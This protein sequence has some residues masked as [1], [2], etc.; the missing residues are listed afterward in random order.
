VYKLKAKYKKL[1]KILGLTI[2]CFALAAAVFCITYYS[3]VDKSHNAYEGPIKKCISDVSK[4]NDSTSSL[5]KNNNLNEELAKKELVNKIDTLTKIKKSITNMIPTEKYNMS[6]NSLLSGLENNIMV[7]RQINEIVKNPQAKDI[8]KALEDLKKYETDCK[9]FY[10]QVSIDGCK[11]SLGD[12]CSKF[13]KNTYA[14]GS[15]QVSIRK[16]NEVLASQNLEFINSLDSIATSFSSL[17]TDLYTDVI[18]GRSSSFDSVISTI[19]KNKEAISLIRQ[20]FDKLSIPA[21][22]VDVYKSLNTLIDNYDAYIQSINYA[23]NVEKQDKED[24]K[25][26]TQADLDQLYNSANTKFTEINDE[27]ESF[28]KLFADYKEQNSNQ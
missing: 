21:K 16:G 28:I 8:E 6:H 26:L 15:H 1:L 12:I 13:V 10:S 4:V 25:S 20:D 27:Y 14:Y 22:A 23:V 11:I 9:T 7:F 3:F 18:N 24:S 2:G 19:D 17:K 5:I